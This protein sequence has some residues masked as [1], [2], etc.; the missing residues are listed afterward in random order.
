MN[1]L[2]AIAAGGAGSNTL[3]RFKQHPQ[4]E[5]LYVNAN[6]KHL[7]K[8]S[9]ANKLCIATNQLN[10]SEDPLSKR[11]IQN[12]IAGYNIIVVVVGLGGN[13]GTKILQ[14]IAA[15]V[16]GAEKVLSVIAFLP[17]K[18]EQERRNQ[19]LSFI[20]NNDLFS[21]R[22]TIIDLELILTNTDD[23]KT[24]NQGF[25]QVEELAIEKLK[26]IAFLT[27][28]EITPE[29]TTPK[30]DQKLEID[31]SHGSKLSV[32]CHL[33]KLNTR[34]GM[35]KTSD[36]EN[37]CTQISAFYE[38]NITAKAK[39]PFENFL[40]NIHITFN[41]R[42][43]MHAKEMEL[44]KL[45]DQQQLILMHSDCFALLDGEIT[46]FNPQLTCLKD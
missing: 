33:L 43:S 10:H 20:D 42:V 38:I 15:E 44:N 6:E 27:E 39:N 5:L 32:S 18:C 28:A 11:E 2:L 41:D 37:V 22:T 31:N 4:Y 36:D 26:R 35:D 25:Q 8:I 21:K 34:D 14:K 19:A 12:A 1:R 29:Q 46:V 30:Q 45:V 9:H 40:F 24:L 16:K 23:C 3:Q 7:A 17:F 13:T